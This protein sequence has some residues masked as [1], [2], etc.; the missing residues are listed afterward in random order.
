MSSAVQ[1]LNIRVIGKVQGVYF[2]AAT[3]ETVETLGINGFIQNERDGSVYLE[4]EG[5]TDQLEKLINWCEKG[6]AGAQVVKVETTSGD[7][8]GFSG[9]EIRRL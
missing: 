1:H 7:V 6:P 2:R 5:N 4:A 3:R 8:K 9:F